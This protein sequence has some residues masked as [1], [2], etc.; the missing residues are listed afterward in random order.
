MSVERERENECS[1]RRRMDTRIEVVEAFFFF[2]KTVALKLEVVCNVSFYLR[3][4]IVSVMRICLSA[5]G[6]RRD[7]IDLSFSGMRM[8]GKGGEEKGRG[9]L[10]KLETG[11]KDFF[12]TSDEDFFIIFEKMRVAFEEPLEICFYGR[13]S[14]Q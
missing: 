4:R 11:V 2:L 3:S 14:H 7:K 9:I 13:K 1:F 8:R 12:C 6:R 10:L 5:S